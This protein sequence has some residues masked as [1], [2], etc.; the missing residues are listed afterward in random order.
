MKVL[1]EVCKHPQFH[2]PRHVL[3]TAVPAPYS[4]LHLPVADHLCFFVQP[5]HEL[6]TVRWVCG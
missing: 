3:I 6:A 4:Y 2:N 5:R 1:A